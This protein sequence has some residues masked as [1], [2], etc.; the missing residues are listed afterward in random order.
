[1]KIALV[2]DDLIQHGGAED[3]LLA[4]TEV[5][6]EATLFTT[7]ATQ[8]WEDICLTRGIP[9]R[10]SFL[11][12]LPFKKKLFR[13]LGPTFLYNIALASFDFSEYDVVFSMSARFAH[14]VLTKP[15]TKHICYMNSPGRMFWEPFSYFEKENKLFFKIISLSLSILRIWDYTSAQRVD[16]FIANS[17]TPQKRIQK[18]YNR[19]STIIYPFVENSDLAEDESSIDVSDYYL[20][21]SRLVAWKKIELAIKACESLNLNLVIVG[22]GTD[23]QRLQSISNGKTKFEGYVTKQRKNQLYKN[24]I[25]FINTQYEDFGITP[26][27]AMSFGK[28]V[29]AFGKGGAL[30]TI[31]PSVTGEFF[32]E[33]TTESLINLL[34]SFNPLRYNA[35]T[36]R[37]HALR[38]SKSNFVQSVKFFVESVGEE[39]AL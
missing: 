30:E 14:G 35:S 10:T 18:Y 27:E 33:Q 34:K 8:E 25:A 20:I 22:D 9:L 3:L 37:E 15:T 1:M 26:L 38:Y 32:E 12:K 19:A 6:P 17:R 28:P 2:F 4:V 24:C 39:N 21:V 23:R 7:I 16:H 11:Q 13:L 31:T 36:C 29:I 5:W